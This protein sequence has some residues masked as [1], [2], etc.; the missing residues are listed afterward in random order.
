M[1][2]TRA[3]RRSSRLIG[4]SLRYIS[5]NNSPVPRVA[6]RRNGKASRASTSQASGSITRVTGTPTIIHCT[7]PISMPYRCPTKAAI[8]A[9][10]G[11]PMRVATPPMVAA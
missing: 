3:T 11:V 2:N 10:G 6:G 1:A 8:K 4:P 5:A 9:L 7:K